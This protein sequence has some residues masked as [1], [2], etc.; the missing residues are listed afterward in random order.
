MTEIP[1]VAVRAKA[2]KH[3][4]NFFFMTLTSFLFRQ[5]TKWRGKASLLPEG[6]F[7]LTEIL[8]GPGGG[9]VCV[10]DEYRPDVN[11]IQ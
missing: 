3:A 5:I 4:T 2:N 10:Q 8:S 6:A 9:F 7:Q 11:E 1:A